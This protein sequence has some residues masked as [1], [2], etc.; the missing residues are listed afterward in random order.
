MKILAIRG[1]NIASLEGDFEVDFRKEPLKSAG[2]FAISGKTGAGKTTI[3]DTMS[4]ALFNQTARLKL[5]ET[6]QIADSINKK[7]QNID[8][9]SLNDPRSMLRRS[10]G[11]GYAEVEFIAPTGETYISRWMVR[12]AGDKPGGKLQGVRMSLLNVTTKARFED[13]KKEVTDKVAEVLGLTFEQFTRSVLLAQGDFAKFLKAGKNEKA[14]LL[15]KITGTEIYSEISK[16]IYDKSTE[17]KF[18]FNQTEALMANITILPDEE[19]A[20][21]EKEEAEL[22]ADCEKLENN[23]SI[24]KTKI[25]WINTRDRL[26]KDLEAAKN[27]LETSN[28]NLETNKPRFDA[29]NLVDSVQE[30]RDEFKKL[31]STRDE[32]TKENKILS[33]SK[34][35]LSVLLEK[36]TSLEQT[37]K[38]QQDK[39]NKLKSEWESIYP[40]VNKARELDLKIV[41]ESSRL[42]EA[43]RELSDST[44]MLDVRAKSLSDFEKEY[45]DA[46]AQLEKINA[47]F[48]P[49]TKF[50]TLVENS[51]VI[52][53]N[54]SDAKNLESEIAKN[55][56]KAE[57]LAKNLSKYEADLV[58]T[59]TKKEKLEQTLTTEIA[60]LREQLE[61]N[62]PCP[63]CGSKE[64]PVSNI[65]V[66]KLE[67]EELNR[68]KEVV[69]KNIL[70]ITENISTCKSGIE[71]IGLLVSTHKETHKNI[72]ASLEAQ[73]SIIDNWHSFYDNNMLATKIEG[74]NDKWATNIKSQQ[75]LTTSETRLKDNISSLKANIEE[76]TAELA[77][78][79]NLSETI[80][81]SLAVIREER[82]KMLD[83]KKADDVEKSYKKSIDEANELVDK[84]STIYNDS[85]AESRKV[86]GSI[87]II[88]DS[89]KSKEVLVTELSQHIDTWLAS[90]E[91]GLQLDELKVLLDKTSSW[92][93][94]ERQALNLIVEAVN[95]AKSRFEERNK[96][97]TEHNSTEGKPTEDES[98]ESLSLNSTSDST[99]LNQ[100]RER[101]SQLRAEMT[102]NADNK[103]KV[104]SLKDELE[105]KRVTNDNWAKLSNLLGSKDG[106]Q[107]KNIA[108]GYTLD[109]LLA[110]ANIHLNK[111]TSRYALD[112]VSIDSLSLQVIDKDMLSEVRSIHTLSGGESFLIS[113]ALALGLASLSSKKMNV[114]SL[115]IDEG[116]G[117]LDA[118]TLSMAMDTL[119][120]LHQ[121]GKKIG[122]ISHVAEMAERITTQIRVNKIST[123]KSIIEII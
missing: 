25:D 40:I 105:A 28:A 99:I 68:L 109:V 61:D 63:V 43:N 116:F 104:G 117:T 4:L 106:N 53:K 5:A 45:N 103:K 41:N 115:F 88:E 48:E 54:I 52:L 37:L 70:Q 84:T 23:I 93:N 39:H 85:I 80:K 1:R 12:R 58:V 36:K 17:A 100:K 62:M 8:T 122:V 86:E 3:L 14:E 30:V 31:Q 9:I 57:D 120:T 7:S 47:W 90:R 119:E 18:E 20:L 107:F 112:R 65:V 92:I 73:L 75:T 33:E 50:S 2:I 51:N 46:I 19:I 94:S 60:K 34:Q 72:F 67:E 21:K 13:S 81:S 22:K 55:K 102:N 118:E 79:T 35:S 114:E 71:A 27:E 89:I 6:G 113:L 59:Q 97:L 56:S 29:L 111:I 123:D 87:A 64:H 83:G 49:R 77:K 42:T 108:Q 121:E 15:E 74:L 110:Y 101:M 11:E 98:I 96:I 78:R 95:K 76:L 32:L 26:T 66:D 69:E 24:I 38:L 44:K 16:R 82:A 10:A 91:D